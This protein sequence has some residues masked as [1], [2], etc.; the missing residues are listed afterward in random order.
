[1]QIRETT[2]REHAGRRVSF[3][4]TISFYGY[5]CTRRGGPCAC[6]N[7]CGAQL[8]LF[9]PKL[10]PPL[11]T[12]IER[13]R[14]AQKSAEEQER[15][16]AARYEQITR[17][18]RLALMHSPDGP[19]SSAAMVG[20]GDLV[21]CGGDEGSICCPI[22]LNRDQLRLNAIVTGTIETYESAESQAPTAYG[23]RVESACRL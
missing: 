22:Q 5:V 12:D 23:I 8:E 16:N 13:D 10:L 19:L 18:P 20:E 11:L 4:G 1:M 3:E 14:L 15:F 6:N 17:L 21:H 7:R 2:L 9:P